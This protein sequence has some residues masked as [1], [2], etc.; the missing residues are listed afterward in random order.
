MS[1]DINQHSYTNFAK[2]LHQKLGIVLGDKRQYLVKSRLS[3]VAR[4]HNY[5]DLN[6]FLND[7][8][9]MRSRVISDQCLELMTTNETYWFRDDYP[10]K[11]LT[12]HVLPSMAD[13]H[14]QLKIWS[15]ACSSGQ[16]VYSICMCVSE[17]MQAN[18]G[19]F[20]MG[21]KVVGTDYSKNMVMHSRDG[22]YNLMALNRGLPPELKSKYFDLVDDKHMQVNSKLRA[23]TEFRQLNLLDNYSSL[24]HF[25]I[26]FCRNV[27]IYFNG[28]EKTNILKKIAACIKPGGG[29]FLGAAESI[30]GVE[31]L[32]KM[33]SI[34]NG[35]YYS[36]L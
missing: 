34:D 26:V 28:N 11:L 1:I 32:Y 6:T 14:T 31:H 10:F 15:S 4:A 8:V 17:F 13:N 16:E 27:L 25:D 5:T 18:P 22:V 19:A 3:P 7:V 29:L 35:L 24:G 21:F 33:Q 9:N 30:S 2:F 23:M 36:A 20:K 12:N